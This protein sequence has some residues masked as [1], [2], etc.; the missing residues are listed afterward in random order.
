MAETPNNATVP[1]VLPVVAE[2]EKLNSEQIRLGAELNDLQI[3]MKDTQTMNDGLLAQL[4]D[5]NDLLVQRES[6]QKVLLYKD[7]SELAQIKLELECTEEKYKYEVDIRQQYLAQMDDK[8]NRF[9]KLKEENELLEQTFNEMSQEL[10]N[11]DLQH[12]M[13]IHEMNKDMSVVRQNLEMSLRRELLQ[14]DHKYQQRAFQG[15]S[16]HFKTDIFEN[17]KLKDEVTLQSIGIAN[18][19]LRL[20]KQNFD[21]DKFR[22]EI[23]ALNRQAFALREALSE[24]SEARQ[25]E[26]KNMENHGLEEA[27][28]AEQY[29]VLTEQVHAPPNYDTL[30]DDIARCKQ[31]ILAEHTKINLWTARLHKLWEVG[32]RIVPTSAQEIAGV[33]SQDTF[34]LSASTTGVGAGSDKSLSRLQSRSKIEGVGENSLAE[35]ESKDTVEEEEDGGVRIADIERMCD[36]DNILASALLGFK[37]KESALVAGKT[38]KKKNDAVEEQKAKSANPDDVL[39]VNMVSWVINEIMN[40]WAVTAADAHLNDNSTSITKAAGVDLEASEV[41]GE[42]PLLRVRS[43]AHVPRDEYGVEGQEGKEQAERA[44]QSEYGGGAF[45]PFAFQSTDLLEVIQQKT[46]EAED[47]ANTSPD[48]PTADPYLL[49]KAQE[50]GGVPVSPLPSSV[51]DPPGTNTANAA[52]ANDKFSLP[53]GSLGLSPLLQENTDIA[54][55]LNRAHSRMEDPP[56][57]GNVS[58]DDELRLGLSSAQGGG[59]SARITTGGDLVE[60]YRLV[61]SAVAGYDGEEGDQA[62][63]DDYFSYEQHLDDTIAVEDLLEE[64]MNKEKEDANKR[65]GRVT[66][67]KPWYRFREEA[68]RLPTGITTGAPSINELFQYDEIRPAPLSFD[69]DPPVTAKITMNM[70]KS[71]KEG[72]LQG[73]STMGNTNSTSTPGSMFLSASTS[74]LKPPTGKGTATGKGG[75]AMNKATSQPVLN[76]TNANPRM[77]RSGSGLV[78]QMP[79]KKPRKIR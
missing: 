3:E 31:A 10:S 49:F 18:L 35:Q 19:S 48:T 1:N 42:Q 52:N 20:Q 25:H 30:E 53:Q 22:E 45:D 67:P 4:T 17:A 36:N 70:N 11:M 12:S 64:L 2:M 34:K 54:V 40:V 60:S 79:A 46:P 57:S 38:K 51:P 75:N 14:M 50:E 28:L 7:T 26:N 66:A 76:F 5:K 72:S 16:G 23:K 78:L 61:S 15:L 6:K 44:E 29:R 58:D 33:Y 56:Q 27:K 43:S 55:F 65:A 73:S 39:T 68:K 37:G 41:N 8:R 77:I 59:E 63:T 74:H 9:L 69:I 71:Q 13:A 21:A 47:S 32:D 62:D 24:I